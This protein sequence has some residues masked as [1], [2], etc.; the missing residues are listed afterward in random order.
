MT[1]DLPVTL[2]QFDLS[3]THLSGLSLAD[4]TFGEPQ[5]IDLLLGV[6]VF[7]DV[8][9]HGWRTRPTGALVAIKTEF[10]WV[11]CGG[12]TTSSDDINLHAA[13]R[14]ASTMGNNDILHKFWEIK[15]SPSSLPVLTLEERSVIQRFDT[16]HHPTKS[17]RFAEEA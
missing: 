12:N 14:H 5:R 9:R 7:V 10:G 2:V 15:E 4:L 8:L 16:N 13:S 6:D 3:W 1:C 11:I 17:R